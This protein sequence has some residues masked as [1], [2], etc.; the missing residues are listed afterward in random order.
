MVLRA[1]PTTNCVILGARHFIPLSLSLFI[2]KMETLTPILHRGQVKELL[3]FYRSLEPNHKLKNHWGNREKADIIGAL[4][5][6]TSHQEKLC[7]TITN[8]TLSPSLEKIYNWSLM[9]LGE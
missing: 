1:R 7:S 3:Y 2:Y 6:W 4:P 8:L 9:S 5:G